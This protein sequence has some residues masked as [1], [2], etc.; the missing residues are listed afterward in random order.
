MKLQES[1]LGSQS[2]AKRAV[3]TH[4]FPTSTISIY[5]TDSAGLDLQSF[6][7]IPTINS[8]ARRMESLQQLNLCLD[9]LPQNQQEA[10]DLQIVMEMGIFR[11]LHDGKRHTEKPVI[12]LKAPDEDKPFIYVEPSEGVLVPEDVVAKIEESQHQ[13]TVRLAYQ[14]L[15]RTNFPEKARRDLME[16]ALRS[17]LDAYQTSS[18]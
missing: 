7:E 9:E 8:V 3:I 6:G 15:E 16:K 12:A 4:V 2:G 5:A 1:L 13:L 17:A 14:A 11:S 10:F 18:L